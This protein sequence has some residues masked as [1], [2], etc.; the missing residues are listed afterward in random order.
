[1]QSPASPPRVAV[2]GVGQELNGDDA[3]GV[4]AARALSQ[5]QRAG[6]SDA[7]RPVPVSLLVIEAAHAPENC[8]GAI[9]RFAPD[10]VILVDAAD[11]GD[12]PGTVR[13]LDWRDA[14]GLGA[15]THTLSLY[16]M[17]RYLATDLACDVGLIGIQPQDTSLG[18]PVSSAVR[19]AARAAAQ[20]LA[21]LL[22]P[23]ASSEARSP[24]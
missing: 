19:R 6:S 15:S 1:M 17:A 22:L 8:T 10:L 13:W 3:A 9:R 16:M 24:R 7:H 14:A 2:V 20:G 18:V 23:R 4:L 11:M 12:P 21:A 5:R